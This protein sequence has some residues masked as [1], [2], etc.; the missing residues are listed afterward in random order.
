MDTTVSGI[1]AVVVAELRAAGYMES[2]VGQYA[3]TIKA[4]TEFSSGREYS[5]VWV[6]KIAAWLDPWL[7]RAEFV[8]AYTTPHAKIKWIDGSTNYPSTWLWRNGVLTNTV[9][10]DKTF[11]YFHFMVW[12]KHWQPQTIPQSNVRGCRI[13]SIT[14]T[15][16]KLL[17]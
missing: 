10:G 6:R 4:L 15:G 7:Q 9:S 2:T 11:P 1:G 14:E 17:E 3:K 5:P 16:F 13:F 12:K 8:E